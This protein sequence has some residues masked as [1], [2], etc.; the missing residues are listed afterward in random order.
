MDFFVTVKLVREKMKMSQEDLA[1]ALNGF[2][3]IYRWENDKIHPNKMTKQVFISL[4]EQH[5]ISVK[6]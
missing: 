4:Y 1:R 2:A 5:G 3:T 6:D